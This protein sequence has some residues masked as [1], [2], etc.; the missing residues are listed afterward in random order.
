MR[1]PETRRP[2]RRV[3]RREGLV[4]AGIAAAGAA[5]LATREG[6]APEKPQRN[7]SAQRDEPHHRPAASP[8]VGNNPA[9]DALEN[10]NSN[11]SEEDLARA[12]EHAAFKQRIADALS[13]AL[14]KGY[15]VQWTTAT[16]GRPEYNEFLMVMGPNGS[17]VG[18][19]YP[20]EV[21]GSLQF[22][23]SDDLSRFYAQT[24]GSPL[25]PVESTDVA[26]VAT[27]A[28]EAQHFIQL[29]DEWFAHEQE[30]ADKEKFVTAEDG[31]VTMN[32]E[33]VSETNAFSSK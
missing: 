19:V 9:E 23:V 30:W 32:P 5:W 28:E 1:S 3:G 27:A 15:N 21:D 26:D 25:G 2:Q 13:V 17:P 18:D 33:Y 14:P 29:R 4:A 12:R 20:D 10:E 11:L 16:D 6:S 22:M 24:L 7:D 31:T 8:D